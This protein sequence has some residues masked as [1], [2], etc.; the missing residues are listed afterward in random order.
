[1][2]STIDWR[3]SPSVAILLRRPLTFLLRYLNIVF[4]LELLCCVCAALICMHSADVVHTIFQTTL[5]TFSSLFFQSYA[6]ALAIACGC[7][8]GSACRARGVHL[9]MHVWVINAVALMHLGYPGINNLSKNWFYFLDSFKIF[10]LSSHNQFYF[11]SALFDFL[12][13]F[14]FFYKFLL[15]GMWRKRTWRESWR[16]TSSS[17]SSFTSSTW[18]QP[19]WWV[20]EAWGPLSTTL[21]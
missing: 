21:L 7:N 16:F 18:G 1:M 5:G 4:G 13:K 15:P 19:C 12:S 14:F 10:S 2:S 11:N 17:P 3:D 8:L 20:P 9:R 6:D